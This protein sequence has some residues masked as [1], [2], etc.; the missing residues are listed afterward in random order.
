MNR[1]ALNCTVS[2]LAVSLALTS[3]CGAR[4]PADA[5]VTPPNRIMD[6]DVLYA[7]NCS[8]CHGPNGTGGVAIGL[9]DPVYLAI[10]DDAILRR[11]T[12]NGAAGTSMPAFAQSSGGILTD[13]QI[14][15]IVSGIRARW[16]RPEAL[17]GANAPPYAAQEPGDPGHGAEVYGTYCSSCHG[18]D[19]HGSKRASSIVDGS[20]LGL[21]SD[22]NL[23][24]TVI[25]GRREWGAPDWRGDVAGRAMSP[26][27]VSDVV[28][29]LAA[30]RRDFP[31]QPYSTALQTPLQAE[32]GIQ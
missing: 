32:G 2:V 3:A 13:D 5:Q 10:A 4:N 21:V 24:T 19:G 29:W 23:R 18:V 14:D 31:G 6:F 26:E 12:A 1:T 11:V 27:D 17:D 28:A 20:Y 15:V 8:G 25:V 16:A 22:Q 7:R 30:Q 9:G